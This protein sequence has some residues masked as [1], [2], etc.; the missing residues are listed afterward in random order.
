MPIVPTWILNMDEYEV[1]IL[2]KAELVLQR[3]LLTTTIRRNWTRLLVE[4]MS[5][6]IQY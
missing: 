2:H 4:S 3:L 5:T 6:C 1:N